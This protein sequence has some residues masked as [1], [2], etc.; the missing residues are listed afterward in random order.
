MNVETA[1]CSNQSVSPPLQSQGVDSQSSE[2]QRD[3]GGH[4]QVQRDEERKDT[5][6]DKKRSE[7]GEGDFFLN[8]FRP[9]N[10]TEAKANQ[11]VC[12]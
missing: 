6:R 9:S 8:L 10:F 5:H 11:N 12:F 7:Q 1:L 4:R 3:T 2:P